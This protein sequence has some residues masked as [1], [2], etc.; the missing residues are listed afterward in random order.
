VYGEKLIALFI[1]SGLPAE[2]WDCTGIAGDHRTRIAG[3]HRTGITGDMA[4]RRPYR[5]SRPQVHEKS[6]E[7]Q[8]DGR[9]T[10][11]STKWCTGIASNCVAGVA[12]NR[13]TGI[14]SN[15]YTGIATHRHTTS[16]CKSC[17]HVCEQSA[18][19]TEWTNKGTTEGCTGVASNHVT[20]I[21]DNHWFARHASDR[22]TGVTAIPNYGKAS[23]NAGFGR[24]C[25][26]KKN[27]RGQHGQQKFVFHH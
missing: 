27:N 6:I 5:E 10:N 11:R 22:H 17:S 24:C 15:R 13:C 9:S 21:T 23:E 7:R 25:S 18:K 16:R 8:T 1:T 14:A 3:D 20:W 4:R 2:A 26:R 19:R 12:N